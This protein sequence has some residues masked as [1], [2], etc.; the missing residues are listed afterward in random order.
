MHEAD[1]FWLEPQN[2]RWLEEEIAQQEAR[3]PILPAIFRMF[4]FMW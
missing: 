2:S 1:K 4:G 3:K